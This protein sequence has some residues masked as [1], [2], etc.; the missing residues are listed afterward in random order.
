MHFIIGTDLEINDG[1]SV[2]GLQPRHSTTSTTTPPTAMLG[3][4]KH[5][6]SPHLPPDLLVL[7]YLMHTNPT[8]TVVEFWGKV[9]TE[10]YGC[11]WITCI[12]EG[13]ENRLYPPSWGMWLT[14]TVLGPLCPLLWKESSAWMSNALIILRSSASLR[15]K[16][17]VTAIFSLRE[18][19]ISNLMIVPNKSNGWKINWELRTDAKVFWNTLLL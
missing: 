6:P 19:Q 16:L 13:Y 11:W 17:C 2:P 15:R 4:P 1:F 14:D 5:W 3:S 8:Q 7:H 9:L 12:I 10:T 18:P